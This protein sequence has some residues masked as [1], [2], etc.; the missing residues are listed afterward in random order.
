MSQV[1]QIS[2]AR[3]ARMSDSKPALEDGY[4]RIVNAVL[5]KMIAFPLSSMEQRLVLAIARKTFGYNKGKDRIAASQLAEM[6]SSD[7]QR[8]SRQ[9]ASTVLAGLIRKQVVIREGGSKAA[10][11]INTKTDEWIR[12]EK[13]TKTPENPRVNRNCSEGNKNGS[14]NRNT[15]LKTN[16]NTVHTKDKKD[17]VSNPSDYLSKPAD[18]TGQVVDAESDP[19]QPEQ[20]DLPSPPPKKPKADKNPVPFNRLVE[21]YHKH[22]PECP[23]FSVWT[24]T[25]EGQ[26]RARW[27]QKVGAKRVPCNSLDFWERFFNYVAKSDFLCGR[28]DPKQGRKRFVA[29]LEWLTKAGNFAKIIEGRYHEEGEA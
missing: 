22:L 29:D 19:V 26:I 28:V 23:E 20:T 21:L 10:I 4:T 8:I 27:S 24:S 2:E 1:I 6:M 13:G 15:V 5:E 25:R 14:L 7:Q 12:P 18:E 9:R 11:K 17:I 3:S 16:P